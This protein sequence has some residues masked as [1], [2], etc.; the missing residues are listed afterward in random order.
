MQ[1]KDEKI[2]IITF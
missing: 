2:Q 1:Y